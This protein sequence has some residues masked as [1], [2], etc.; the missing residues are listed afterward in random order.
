MLISNGKKVIPNDIRKLITP[1]CLAHCI[2][3]DGQ[4]VAKG[5]II[6]CT[7]NYTLSEVAILIA[8]LKSNFNADCNI[9]NKKVRHGNTYYR[10]Y[11]K[12]S[13][14]DSIKPLI[15]EYIHQSFLYK[16]HK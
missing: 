8:A 3:G 7:N 13:S 9:H 4:H 2:C 12:K 11:I 6:L 14:F 15:I 16:L 10:I 5:G 1:V